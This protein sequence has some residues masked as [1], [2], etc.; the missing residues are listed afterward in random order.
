MDINVNRVIV[1]HIDKEHLSTGSTL[2]VSDKLINS[3]T[4]KTTELVMKLDKSY[5]NKSIQYAY[6]NGSGTIYPTNLT[7]YREDDSDDS[8]ISKTANLV[9]DLNSRISSIASASGGYIV[10]CDYSIED[11]K[12]LL[13]VFLIRMTESFLFE[14]QSTRSSDGLMETSFSIGDIEHL[15]LKK[16]AMA[17]RVD[18]TAY[19]Q[20]GEEIK[21][22]NLIKSGQPDISDYF[23]N[24]IGVDKDEIESDK[25][26]T[27]NLRIISETIPLPEISENTPY[28]RRE[29]IRDVFE[30][31][32]LTN[33]KSI[34]LKALSRH[35]YR[36]ENTI[37][38]F[39]FRENIT[40]NTEFKLN[41]AELRLFQQF[42]FKSNGIQLQFPRTMLDD[43]RVRITDGNKIIIEDEDLSRKIQVEK[44]RLSN[45]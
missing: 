26:Y 7:G 30:Y 15:D 34:N 32:K 17:C 36:D 22:L 20:E 19:E 9:R 39:A 1:H 25:E 16:L 40:I 45:N 4:E 12:D 44:N 33:R 3:T 29:F 8:F 6:F 37:E 10:F 28:T 43:D 14:E 18:M 21:Y 5:R 23:Y 24:W 13:G 27:Q 38:E 35:F 31:I 2:I 11:E 42:E 41:A